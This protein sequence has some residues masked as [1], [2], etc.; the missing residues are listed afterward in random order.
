M[1]HGRAAQHGARQ[2]DL[3]LARKPT[4]QQA[5]RVGQSREALGEIDVRSKLGMGD[6]VDQEIVEEIDEE[7]GCDA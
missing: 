2:H 7:P 4:N 6:E 5:R 1:Q 3:V